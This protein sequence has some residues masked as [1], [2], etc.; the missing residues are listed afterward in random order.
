MDSDRGY[1]TGCE[2]YPLESKPQR[3]QRKRHKGF[4]LPAGVLSVTRPGRWGNP[5]STAAE[6]REHL[7]LASHSQLTDRT[8]E[9]ERMRRI[10]GSLEELRGKSLA[11]WCPVGAECHADVL[12]E[13]ANR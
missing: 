1:V 7:V 6:F 2:H 12:I 13:F 5:F 10:A 3:V 8:Q 9:A 11:C 4:R